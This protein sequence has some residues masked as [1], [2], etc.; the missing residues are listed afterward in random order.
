MVAKLGG[1]DVPI[2]LDDEELV[3]RPTLYAAQTISRQSG[4]IAGAV[5]RV[6]KL[7]FDAVLSVISIGLGYG[8]SKK[9][10]A[11][12]AERIW[13]TGLSDDTGSLAER[14]VTYLRVLSA[15]G[16]LPQKEKAEEDNQE[17]ANPPK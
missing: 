9:A 15:G 12:L 5:E 11:D 2:Q 1:G 17:P 8:P 10:P 16:R 7:D 3:L 6:L 13:R 14:A 4:G